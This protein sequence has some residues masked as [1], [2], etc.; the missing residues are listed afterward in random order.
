MRRM[1]FCYIVVGLTTGV[2]LLV[3]RQKMSWA[4]DFEEKRDA[5]VGT[6]IKSSDL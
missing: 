6:M 5:R 1:S 3:P 2:L 4:W